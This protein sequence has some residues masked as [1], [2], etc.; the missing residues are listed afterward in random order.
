MRDHD[1]LGPGR[2]SACRAN[3]NLC[4]PP[5]LARRGMFY[6]ILYLTNIVFPAKNGHW[7]LTAHH[8]A[9]ESRCFF[10]FFF[11]FSVVGRLSECLCLGIA[12]GREEIVRLSCQQW[13]GSTS[14][15]IT[16]AAVKQRSQKDPNSCVENT[17][18]MA[19]ALIEATINTQPPLDLGRPK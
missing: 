5:S 15:S 18:Y 14:W 2:N 13:A 8:G 4:V 7:Q 12:R 3:F 9:S 19:S 16:S 17:I 11:Y 1:S 6:F 10:L